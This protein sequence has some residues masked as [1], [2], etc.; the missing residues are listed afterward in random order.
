MNST[1]N[2]SRLAS[3]IATISAVA[4]GTGLG[5]VGSVDAQVGVNGATVSAFVP[6]GLNNPAILL[7]AI[8][9]PGAPRPDALPE[10][11]QAVINMFLGSASWGQTEFP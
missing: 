1:K 5:L 9:E 7:S 6:G 11:H 4:L 3:A 10:R 8:T 2:N